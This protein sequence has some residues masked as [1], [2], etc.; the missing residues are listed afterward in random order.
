[1]LKIYSTLS[2]KK[3]ILKSRKSKKINLFV[4]GVTTYDFSHLGH[5]R[6]YIVFDMIAK[7]LRQRRYDVFYLQ[8]VTDVDD[9]IIKRAREQGEDSG[10]LARRFEKEYLADMK[11]LGVNAVSKYARATDY[12]PEIMNQVQHL[13]G[14]GY[15]YEIEGDGIYFDISKFK[16]YGKLSGRTKEQAQDAVSRIDESVNKRNKGDFA[17]WKLSKPGEPKWKSSWGWGRPGWHIEDTAITEKFFGPQYDI[18]GGAQDLIFPHH[19]A[20]VTQMESVSGKKP[21]V[22]YWMHTGF[23]TVRGEKMS[24]SLGNFV[25]IRDFLK[26]YSPRLLRF[27]V[28]KTHWRSPIDY[29]TELLEQSQSELGRIDEF[30]DRLQEKSQIHPFIRRGAQ[31]HDWTNS[32]LALEKAMDDDFNTPLAISVL[33]DLIRKGNTMANEGRMTKTSVKEILDFLNEVDEFFGFIFWGREKQQI[34]E[35]IKKLADQREQFRKSENWEK[36]DELRKELQRKG[37]A[38]EDIPS[39]WKLKKLVYQR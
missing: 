15:A 1:M 31:S 20:E 12:I 5:A 30:V 18:H 9:K 26:T 32:K 17:L 34:P 36:A 8:N 14:K 39:G 29:S 7:Y 4:C 10:K 23:L 35:D 6:T 16:E 33:F 37:W 21:F 3:E 2:R 28:L 19:E 25:T 27:F 38:I 22:K 13:L 11:T 24:K